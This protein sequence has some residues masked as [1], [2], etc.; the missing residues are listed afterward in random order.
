MLDWLSLT[1]YAIK[2]DVGRKEVDF[3]VGKDGQK[4]AGKG[5]PGL[6]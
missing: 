2:N 6:L 1:V 5:G 3:M 4:R